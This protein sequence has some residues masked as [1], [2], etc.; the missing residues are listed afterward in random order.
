[1]TWFNLSE[2]YQRVVQYVHNL[3][4]TPDGIQLSDHIQAK[5]CLLQSVI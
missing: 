3:Q 2:A 1:M 5:N 4:I